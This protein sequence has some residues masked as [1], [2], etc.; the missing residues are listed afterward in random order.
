MWAK[1]LLF[2]TVLLIGAVYLFNEVFPGRNE[3]KF[4]IP[5]ADEIGQIQ[6]VARGVDL[7]FQQR[8]KDKSLTPASRAE[9]LQIARRLSLGLTGTIPSLEEIRRFEEIP[10]EDRIA[11]WTDYLLNDVRTADYLAERLARSYVGTEDGPFIVYRRR[12]F[13][14]WLSEQL[15]ENRPYD[16]IVRSLLTDNGLWTDTPSV[17][18]Y[19]VTIENDEGGQPNPIRLAA[20]TT[21][22][23]LGMRIDCL[24]CHDDALGTLE[25]TDHSF[26]WGT[27]LKSGETRTGY[28]EDFHQLAAAFSSVRQTAAGLQDTRQAKPYQFQFLDEETE[29]EVAFKVPFKSELLPDEGTDRQRLAT[30]MTHTDNKAF[31]RALVNRIWAQMFGR[32]LHD[33]IDDIPLFGKRP[34]GMDLLADDFIASGY[35]LRRLIRIIGQTRVFQ[36]AA[37]SDVDDFDRH[38]HYRAV[39]EKTPLRPEQVVGSLIQGSSLTTIDSNSNVFQKLITFGD[40]NEF[41]VRYGDAGE[42]EF[43]KRNGTIQQKNIMMNGKVVAE[44]TRSNDLLLNAAAQINAFAESD[45]LAVEVLFLTTLTRRPTKIEAD[46]LCDFLGQAQNKSQRKRK[47]EDVLWTLFNKSEFHHNH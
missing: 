39:F 4:D 9:D 26:E 6:A 5:V 20:R 11:W 16:Q 13:V 2:A 33:P 27:N 29:R 35:D 17:N 25:L 43:R 41:V 8:W 1:N 22:A 37:I 7:E 19:T 44:R 28:Q 31:A 38:R 45:E 40:I 12:R 14:N 32:P 24:Q 21:R 23:F 47:I 46:Y 15:Q 42:D 10:Q 34:A 18:F 30:W 3:D 36:M